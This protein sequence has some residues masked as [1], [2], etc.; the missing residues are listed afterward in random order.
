MTPD[1]QSTTAARFLA[2]AEETARAA[3]GVALE[4]FRGVMEVRSKGGKDIVTEYDTAA[5]EAALRVIRL[6][7]PDHAI[8]AE[9][10]GASVG[11]EV[12][13][14]GAR[15]V[16]TVDPIDGTH[17]Y[18]M[19]LPFWCTAV[20]V[21]DMQTGLVE[22]GVV[23]D[24]LHGELFAATRGGGATLNGRPMRVSGKTQL[25]DAILACDIGYQPE[26]AARMMG[27]AA[28][29]QP[30][31]KRLRLLGSAV[32]AMAYVAAGRFDTYYHLSLQP[33]DIAAA[34]LLVS[35]AGGAITDWDGN[36]IGAKMTSAV[37][38]NRDLQ[39]LVRELLRGGEG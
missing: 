4:G 38:A 7:F 8:L 36:E 39:P 1:Q 6:R 11:S 15:W 28:W 32:L 16:W 30:H 27:L 9:E 20:A 17:N 26:V 10:S 31:V 29:V 19:Q 18:A 22:S 34:S 12:A 14:G 35:E 3:G 24:A 5:E 13:A 23:Y 33:W 2:V 21:A 37:A 25:Q